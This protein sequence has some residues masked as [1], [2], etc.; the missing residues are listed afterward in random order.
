MLIGI[1]GVSFMAGQ[2]IGTLMA[3]HP[4]KGSFGSSSAQAQTIQSLATPVSYAIQRPQLSPL[5]TPKDIWTCDVA[6][7][8]GSLGGVAAAAQAMQTGATTCLIELTPWL[9]GQISSQGVS[10]IDESE[11]MQALQNFSSSWTTFK[12]LIAKQPVALP[13][14]SQVRPGATVQDVNSCWVGRLCFTPQAGAKAAQDYLDLAKAKA[15]NS[16]IGTSIAFK[17]A[18]FDRSGREII[19][20]YGVQRSPKDPNYLPSG[21]LSS[22]LMSWYGWSSDDKYDKTPIKLQAP[23]GKRMIVID[24]TDTGEL[25]GWSGIPHRLGADSVATTGETN[26]SQQDNP[27]CTQA[28]TYPFVLG[29][30]N[31]QGASQAFL[32]QT[33]SD[34]SRDEHRSNYDM[35]GF[36]MFGMRGLFQYRRL[37]STAIT[38]FPSEDLPHPG[39]LT[40]INWNRGNDWSWMDP[41]LILT[42]E[43]LE[44]SGQRQNWMG[45]LS[46]VALKH[47]ESHALL[48]AQWLMETQ[49]NPN[50]PLTYVRGQ[51]GP[52]G[53]VSGLSMYPY[54]REGRRIVGRPAYGQRD[55]VVREGDLRT[56]MSGGRN[57]QA[58]AIGV[59]HY[60]IDI[61]GCRYRNWGPSGEASSAP[62]QE[63]VVRPT[64]LP[65][66]SLIPQDVNNVLMGGKAIAVTH[67]ANAMTRVHYGEWTIGS[68]AGATAGWLATAHNNLMPADIVPKK[69]VKPLQQYLVAQG[70]RLTW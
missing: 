50:Y 32:S 37:V 4:D 29:I 58:T 16:R 2:G 21:R 45:G 41:P 64:I 33:E 59:T 9:G 34:Y 56:D 27:D 35:E 24:A 53:T 68:A 44:Q 11:T 18:E 52:M 70:I 28:F 51:A 6:V 55:F 39:D 23:P 62:A 10:A 43:Q 20:I 38:G 25:V 17:G 67:I 3:T 36:S 31:D 65:L 49:A 7:I 14:W 26:A 69:Q 42:D 54:I 12:Q 60:D 8:G 46:T 57:F 48:F 63:D 5:P 1:Y 30:H 13:E 47:G 19:A 66:E 61:H 22:E 15:P 40:M